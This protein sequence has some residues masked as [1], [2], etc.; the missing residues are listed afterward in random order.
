[1]PGVVFRLYSREH[2]E[3]LPAYDTPE[4]RRVSLSATIL[5]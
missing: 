2:F 1:M 4:I 3:S 5:R